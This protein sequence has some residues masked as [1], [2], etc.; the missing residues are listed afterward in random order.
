MSDKLLKKPELKRP[1]LPQRPEMP[2]PQ[3]PEHAAG[4]TAAPVAAPA[5]APS[6]RCD[7][8]GLLGGC[9]GQKR[10]CGR[11]MPMIPGPLQLL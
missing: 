11:V 2:K 6:S 7:G 8:G 9:E 3:Q 4:P 10:V 5:A 1:E